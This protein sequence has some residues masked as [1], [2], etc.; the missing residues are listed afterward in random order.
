MTYR[1]IPVIARTRNQFYVFCFLE[2]SEELK[3]DFEKAI[4]K[5]AQFPRSRVY[6]RSFPNH[7]N[8]AKSID[9]GLDL[10]KQGRSWKCR[11]NCKVALRQVADSLVK[12]TACD[13]LSSQAEE[14]LKPLWE[15]YEIE[16][17]AWWQEFWEIPEFIRGE[18]SNGYYKKR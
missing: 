8:L 1:D 7:Y 6:N 3:Q 11:A 14:I 18:E 10:F 5:L 15:R 2:F 13:I 12:A 9:E 16:Q 17:W 4:W